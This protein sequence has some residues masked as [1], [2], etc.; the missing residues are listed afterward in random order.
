MSCQGDP[1]CNSWAYKFLGLLC[2][3]VLEFEDSV[4]ILSFRRHQPFVAR[5]LRMWLLLLRHVIRYVPLPCHT[6]AQS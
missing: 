3:A 1:A 5:R 6:S 2:S 4:R